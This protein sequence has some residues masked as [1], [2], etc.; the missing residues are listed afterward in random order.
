MKITFDPNEP[1][2]ET[3]RAKWDNRDFVLQ[4]WTHT[5]PGGDW[6]KPVTLRLSS[7][8]FNGDV[9]DTEWID[10]SRDLATL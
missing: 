9:L 4:L 2:A 1:L 8:T 6:D 7:W 5:N 3:I 10:V